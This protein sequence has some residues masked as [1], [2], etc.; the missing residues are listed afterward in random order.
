MQSFIHKRNFSAVGL[1]Q[2]LGHNTALLNV[3]CFHLNKIWSENE[4]HIS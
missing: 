3:T 4:S 1:E 2:R